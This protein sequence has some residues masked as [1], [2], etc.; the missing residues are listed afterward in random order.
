VDSTMA[1]QRQYPQSKF[2]GRALTHCYFHQCDRTKSSEIAHA[3]K[4][5]IESRKL[6]VHTLVSAESTEE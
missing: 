2:R 4:A 6:W 3:T 1:Y 5:A